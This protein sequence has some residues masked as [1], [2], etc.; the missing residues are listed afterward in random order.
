MILLTGRK[1]I[2]RIKSNST[3]TPKSL[4]RGFT[5]IE[6]LLVVIILGAIVGLS[7]PRFSKT[8]S[9]LLLSDKSHN[10]TYLM[11]YAQ[12]RSIA[13]RTN[14]SLNFDQARSRYW[15]MKRSDSQ[16]N[17]FVRLQGK[18]GRVFNINEN[19]KLDCESEIIIFYPDGKMD[20][21]NIYLSNSNNKFYTISTEAQS[22]YV[23]EFDYKK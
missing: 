11:R 13:E 3:P 5:F 15:L 19:L 1:Q 21:V 7:V 14:Y 17:E 18:F 9:N 4:L 2:R 6:L 12:A 8:Y 16:D 20:K 23:R 10:L 22:G